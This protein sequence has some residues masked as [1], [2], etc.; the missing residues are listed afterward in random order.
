MKTGSLMA[1][2]LLTLIAAAHV[3]RVVF[4]VDIVVGGTV[5]PMWPSVVGTLVTGGVAFLLWRERRP[6]P[7]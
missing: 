7:A 5:V 4:G 3:V 2:V 6:D 1:T